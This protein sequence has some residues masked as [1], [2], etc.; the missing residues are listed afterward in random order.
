MAHRAETTGAVESYKLFDI[1]LLCWP[2]CSRRSQH[3]KVSSTFPF[4]SGL[5][6]V[7]VCLFLRCLDE[8]IYAAKVAINR[9]LCGGGGGGWGRTC[10][11]R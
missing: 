8:G 11:V 2:P 6:R 3:S 4:S 1:V 5:N 7:F 9:C 10:A